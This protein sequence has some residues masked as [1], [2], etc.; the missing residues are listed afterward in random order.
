MDFLLSKLLPL[1]VFPLGLALLLQVAGLIGR[2]RRWGAWLSGAGLA[3]LW[4]AA[5]PWTSRLLVWS[6]EE[7][8]SRLTPSPLPRADAVLVLGGGLRAALPPRQRVELGDAGDRLLNG[9]ALVRQGLAPV[10]V[11]SGGRVSFT[12]ADPAP[13][14]AESAAR[15]ALELGV[16]AGRIVR[17]QGPGPDGPRTTAE[18]A[19]AMARLAQQRGWR[20]LL[21]ITSA[22]HLPRAL[23]SF[24]RRLPPQS[25]LR[26][27]PVACDY[28]LPQRQFLGRPT[29]ASVLLNLL[30]SAEALAGTTGALKEHIGLMVY[31]QRGQAR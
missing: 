1:L 13:P 12:A 25:G 20:S 23:A 2:R 29:A 22:T 10:L 3:L 19:E 18:E 21:L 11:V 14:E 7:R 8:A 5:M 9:V 30:P 4:L 6:L 16:P 17:L 31:R 28:R 24:E 15:L 26:V 27:I